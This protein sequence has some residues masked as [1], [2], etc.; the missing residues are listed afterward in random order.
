MEMEWVKELACSYREMQDL[1]RS[2]DL[3]STQKRKLI[4]SLNPKYYWIDCGWLSLEN[5]KPRDDLMVAVQLKEYTEPFGK[6]T[7]LI[8]DGKQ[9]AFLDF[10]GATGVKE[11]EVEYWQPLPM[12]KINMDKY[13]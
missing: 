12:A 2:S 6:V 1:I 7:A 4:E 9:G 13:R 5:S 8:Y 3:S 11:S 10:T